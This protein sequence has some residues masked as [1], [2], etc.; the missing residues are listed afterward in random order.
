MRKTTGLILLFGVLIMS[1][2]LPAAAELDNKNLKGVNYV[3]IKCQFNGVPFY[4]GYKSPLAEK[5]EEFNAEEAES[6]LKQAGIPMSKDNIR[7][8][9]EIMESSLKK[10]GIRILEIKNNADQKGTTI[11]PTLSI[12]VDVM[13]AS[14]ELYF[15]LV[16]LTVS[17]WISTW[18]GAENIS[19]RVISW[20]QKEMLASGPKEL[21][22]TIE[23]AVKLLID[24]FISQLKAANEGQKT[25]DSGDGKRCHSAPAPFSKKIQKHAFNC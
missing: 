18:L 10:A 25:G 22:E 6:Q 20:W 11:I 12:N 17:K 5:A 9:Y 1:P 15:T 23:K 14:K 3:R 16:Q 2:L 4:K 21:N 8:I 19:T 24:D 7:A 13:G